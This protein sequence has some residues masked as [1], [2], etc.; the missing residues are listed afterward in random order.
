MNFDLTITISVIL[1]LSAILSPILVS[2]INNRHQL[3]LKKI[4]NYDIAKRNALEN[5]TKMAGEYIG[6]PTAKAQVGMTNNLY[7]LIPYFKIDFL[8][9]KSI[10][11]NIHNSEAIMETIDNLLI[12]LKK[13]L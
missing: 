8:S 4:E 9:I 10:I 6:L 5:F 12:E 1:A 2:I 7:G 13:Q 3:K 11:D